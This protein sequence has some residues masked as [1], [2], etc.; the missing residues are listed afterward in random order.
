MTQTYCLKIKAEVEVETAWEQLEAQGLTPLFSL[1]DEGEKQIFI[2]TELP[3]PLFERDFDFI[4][5]YE[6]V[7][8]PEIDWNQQW[9]LQERTLEEG[10]LLIPL[11]NSITLKMEPGPGFGDLSHPTTQLVVEMMQDRV[12][13]RSVLDVGCGSGIL[14]LC[15]KAWGAKEVYGMDCDPSAVEHA[16]TNAKHNNMD[17]AFG[18]PEQVLSWDRDNIFILMNMISS[19][20]TQAWNGLTPLHSHLKEGITSGVLKEQEKDYL[21]LTKSW[22][23][24]L[25]SKQEKDGW[26]AFHF[27]LA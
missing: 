25:L 15:A 8:L 27:S 20:Q 24:T 22:G 19:E 2:S 17:I 6:K 11:E 9:S 16:I 7:P 12:K 10:F 13:G 23:W 3:Q 18:F 1:E 4:E 14:S 21:K 5:S 26:L